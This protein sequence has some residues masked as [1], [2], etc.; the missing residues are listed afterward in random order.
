MARV[1]FTGFRARVL[2]SNGQP[3][4]V[5]MRLA[6]EDSSTSSAKEVYSGPLITDPTLGS[7]VDLD[8][9]GWGPVDGI[10][11]DVGDYNVSVEFASYNNLGV[12]VWARDWTLHHL[13]G[14]T[15]EYSTPANQMAIYV[16]TV[17][18]I[19]ALSGAS[20][21][22]EAFNSGYY[23]LNDGGQGEWRW[24]ADSTMTDDSGAYLKPNGMSTAVP[25]RWHRIMPTGGEVSVKLWGA[26]SGAGNIS[27]N[28]N[29]AKTW[30][31]S[32]GLDTS[33]TLA[34]P[35]GVY[36]ISNATLL[37]DGAGI[38]ET[39]VTRKM[40]Y[41]I[42]NGAQFIG[43]TGGV[44]NIVNPCQV[45]SE[46]QLGFSPIAI[47]FEAGSVPYVRT[48]W[49]GGGSDNLR[50]TYAMTAGL[51]IYINEIV[52]YTVAKII[53]SKVILGPD[54]NISAFA[55]ITFEAGVE[56]QGN[57]RIVF[58]LGTG[59]H[60]FIRHTEL[61]A[62]WFGYGTLTGIDQTDALNVA[63]DTA[64]HSECTLVISNLPM[65]KGIAG[66]VGLTATNFQCRVEGMI[67]VYPNANIY[68]PN[69]L[70]D[71]KQIFNFV[72]T[73]S[74]APISI[75]QG[76]V[77]PEWFGAKSGINSDTAFSVMMACF[78]RANDPNNCIRWID[79]GGNSYILTKTIYLTVGGMGLKDMQIVSTTQGSITNGL[80]YIGGDAV[81]TNY[82]LRGVCIVHTS[83]DEIRPTIGLYKAADVTIQDCNILSDHG[84]LLYA[85]G[86]SRIIVR[87]SILN[88]TNGS[89]LWTN[90]TLH[91]DCSNVEFYQNTVYGVNNKIF[92]NSAVVQTL[93]ALFSNIHHNKFIAD[94]T[95]TPV[96]MYLCRDSTFDTSNTGQV[97]MHHNLFM[98]ITVRVR[99]KYY[100]SIKD[101]DMRATGTSVAGTIIVQTLNEGE[102][103]SY[104]RIR[105][106]NALVTL[107]NTA[108]NINTDPSVFMVEICNNLP[109]SLAT[110]KEAQCNFNV[111]RNEGPGFSNLFPFAR[112][113]SLQMS[114]LSREKTG[115]YQYG[116][117]GTQG[118]GDGTGS[119]PFY[120]QAN[121]NGFWRVAAHNTSFSGNG[122]NWIHWSARVGTSALHM[123]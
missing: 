9:E 123:W 71:R 30:C 22:G 109:N 49:Y 54:S 13:Q 6:F 99:T 122:D 101:N 47:N 61:H 33:I 79:G 35:P 100:T 112:I 85:E 2:D 116:P 89:S 121:L 66:Q 84:I 118:M 38:V 26:T 120:A 62:W 72:G 95:A 74:F 51:P 113:V 63:M 39:G 104:L 8:A 18:D 97:D 44:I 91:D 76:N 64:S 19:R 88:L 56:V 16:D 59:G 43:T 40:R 77:Y 117:V 108:G 52:S 17:A 90:P 65:G 25:G 42:Y 14:A 92:G 50:L 68:F 1:L 7:L 78:Q 3:N 75:A 32:T 111:A 105:D 5:G 11:L 23:S 46:G 81:T 83:N 103:A 57:P 48:V 69:I 55:A 80:I 10:W 73:P 119:L 24:V 102:V 86:S 107:D 12:V 4:N 15:A 70:A 36:N 110:H 94:T 115:T 114:M 67:D 29:N 20:L 28:F 93:P 60:Y 31:L 82:G 45:D 27:G 53:T 21:V 98:G 37:M 34:F 58:G 41:H 87:D 96:N 106:N